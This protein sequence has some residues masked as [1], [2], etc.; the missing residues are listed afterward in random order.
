L[1]NAP[2]LD[3]Y[4]LFVE[5]QASASQETFVAI[6]LS[7]IR[8]DFL[9][10]GMDGS[11]IFLLKDSSPVSYHPSLQFRYINVSFQVTCQVQ[12]DGA[13]LEDQFA[14]VSCDADTPDLHELFVRCFSAA[15]EELPENAVTSDL[16][17]CT[18]K[19]LDLFRAMSQP[20]NREI[21]GLW[22]ELFVITKSPDVQRAVRTWHGGDFDRF[23]FWWNSGCVEVKASAKSQR[24]HEFA[25]EQLQPP[26]AETGYV[27]SLLM[28]PI[29]GG[30]GAIELAK[31]IEGH[32]VREPTLKQ[33]LWRNIAQALGSDF[34]EKLD[35]RFDAAYADRNLRV[36]FMHEIPAISAPDDG[37]ISGI[38]FQSDLSAVNSIL[39]GS[40]SSLLA[41]VFK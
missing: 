12:V 20:G 19:L 14:V 25:L 33:K 11:P 4:S 13:V 1:S 17:K 38:R 31:E 15:V 29:S 28:Q 26:S 24:I 35:R 32:L 6:Q 7:G 39:S 21:L 22:A 9:T 41:S 30:I 18:L 2:D 16:E 10:K 3:L 40:A 27:L 23:D 37:R 8:K 5:L 36:Y 34:S